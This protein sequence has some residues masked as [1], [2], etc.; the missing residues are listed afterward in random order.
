[1]KEKEYPNYCNRGINSLIFT[2]K[3]TDKNKEYVLTQFIIFMW[4]C[5]HPK[6]KGVEFRV[7]TC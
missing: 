3:L 7:V 6:I 5:T 1:M 4:Q 2:Q